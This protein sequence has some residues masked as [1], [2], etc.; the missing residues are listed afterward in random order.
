MKKKQI[1][2]R[3]DTTAHPIEWL[4]F[5]GLIISSVVEHR[6]QLDQSL[7]GSGYANIV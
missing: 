4:K 5:E 2:T 7:I 1:K 3:G 6:K